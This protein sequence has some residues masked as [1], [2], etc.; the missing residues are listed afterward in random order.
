MLPVM[1]GLFG[2]LNKNNLQQVIS[3]TNGNFGTSAPSLASVSTVCVGT[4][5][6]GD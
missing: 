4:G 5:F 1:C 2:E 6:I 3:N